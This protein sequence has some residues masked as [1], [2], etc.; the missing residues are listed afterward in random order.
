MAVKASDLIPPA[1]HPAWR[2]M[3]D[4]AFDEFWLKGGR[5]S[6][7]STVAALRAVTLLARDPLANFACYKKHAVEIE[8]SVYAEC[9]KAIARLG[10]QDAFRC[11]ASPYEI[12]FRPTGQKIFFRGLDNPGK[13]KGV[14][15]TVGYIQG[16]WFEEAD[17]FRGAREVDTVLQTLGR[18]GPR[19]HALYTYNPP[20]SSSSW[21]NAEAARANPLRLVLHT[22]YRDIPEA[23]LGG[24]FFRKMEAIRA[25]SEMRYRHEYLGE[26]TGTGSEIFTRV[27]DRRFTDAE[28]AAMRSRRW[29]MDFGQADPTTLV[30]TNY[31][32]RWV[33]D[34]GGRSEDVGGVLQV[35]DEWYRCDARNAEVVEAVGR[36]GLMSTPIVGDPGGGGKGVIGEMRHMGVRGIRQAYKPA[37]SVETGIRFCRNCLRIEIDAARCP[38]AWREFTAYRYE[39]LRDGTNRNEP[40]DRDNHTIDA[41]RYSREDDIFRGA[42]SRLLL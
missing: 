6:A 7:K 39:T 23:W 26:V 1:Y 40:P 35:F 5:G 29:G 36:R 11:I 15:A 2:A 19:F 32:P 21:V 28:I 42:R 24:F 30:G 41:V 34:G 10:W 20:E 27:V 22:T 17:Q 3:R 16:A 25:D 9:V 14:T 33:A 13:S 31:E 18:G 4:F 12:T 8:T 38:N 37:G